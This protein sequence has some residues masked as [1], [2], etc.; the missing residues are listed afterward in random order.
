MPWPANSVA[1]RVAGLFRL[2]HGTGRRAQ[3]S[4]G[5][6]HG[7]AAT[8]TAEPALSQPPRLLGRLRGDR[9]GTAAQQSQSLPPNRRRPSRGRSRSPSPEA[10]LQGRGAQGSAADGAGACFGDGCVFARFCQE[11]VRRHAADVGGLLEHVRE[12]AAEF[13]LRL[14]KPVCN[15]ELMPGCFSRIVLRSGASPALLGPGEVVLKSSNLASVR[16]AVQQLA[17]R[18]GT[19]PAPVAGA[20]LIATDRSRDL[21]SEVDAECL[22]SSFRALAP[23][24]ST[25]LVACVPFDARAWA[26]RVATLQAGAGARRLA[27]A[28][29]PSRVG[30]R[31]AGGVVS[32]AATHPRGV[33]SAPVPMASWRPHA[34][35]QFHLRHA[36]GV[37][38]RGGHDRK[39]GGAPA[40]MAGV[41]FRLTP[42]HHAHREL[43]AHD[44]AAPARAIRGSEVRSRQVRA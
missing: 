18:M 28:G 3:S 30:A 42:R 9:P 29:R 10:V 15:A 14:R 20:L 32:A 13:S 40:A 33:C 34:D 41:M 25:L 17:V 1:D 21:G 6:E 24:D 37:T 2:L 12:E 35:R 23:G 7:V 44:A 38:S 16:Q 4:W 36:L 43:S 5:G 22:T 26:D 19:A 8:V 27:H 39:K 11:Q 31:G